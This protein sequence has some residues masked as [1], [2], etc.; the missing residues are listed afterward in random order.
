M[1]LASTFQR[2]CN[3]SSTATPAGVTPGSI[4]LRSLFSPLEPS[5]C[6]PWRRLVP[7][8]RLSA[9]RAYARES[10][11]NK[12]LL[13]T[14]SR[15]LLPAIFVGFYMIVWLLTRLGLLLFQQALARNGVGRCSSAGRGRGVRP[16]LGALARGA[17]GPLP[18]HPAGAVV[19]VA[20]DARIPLP[21]DG[22][23]RLLGPVRGG[24]RVLLLRGVQRPLQLR[25]GGLPDLSHR[26]GGQHLAELPHRHHPHPDRHRHAG[27]ALR[28]RR[29]MRAAWSGGPRGCSAWLSWAFTRRCS[30]WP[31]C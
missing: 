30:P 18:H 27:S 28:A 31:R 26:G 2:Y 24:G 22:Y 13:L 10:A 11:S 23:R 15:Y 6:R 12:P 5:H 8:R 21:L 1:D 14:E 20:G 29:P 9:S 3:L 25:G 19:P 7:C 16:R 17:D 4:P